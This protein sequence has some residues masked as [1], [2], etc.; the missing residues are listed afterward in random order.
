MPVSA[1]APKVTFEAAE[2]VITVA[3]I[4]C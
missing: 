4:R 2:E 1:V 3:A